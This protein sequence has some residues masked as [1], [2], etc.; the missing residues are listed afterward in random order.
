MVLLRVLRDY[1]IKHRD[2]LK[3]LH[4]DRRHGRIN[5]VNERRL[6]RSLH[7]IGVVA[8]PVRQRYQRIKQPS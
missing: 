2:V 5:R 6:F 1:I 8:C 7:E 3:M 4:E